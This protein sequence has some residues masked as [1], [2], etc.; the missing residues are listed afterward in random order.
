MY[1]LITDLIRW[2]YVKGWS[3]FR[4]DFKAKLKDT[5]DMFSIGD[6]L[7][8][9][10]KPYRQIAANNDSDAI[11]GKLNA[12]LDK[13]VSRFVGMITRL[14]LIFAGVIVM[15]LEIIIG[16]VMILIWPLIPALPIAGVVLAIVGVAL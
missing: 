9:L 12:F 13:L 7:R 10:F 5:A 2:W 6:L 8:T 15:L 14:V 1:M 16:G 11:Q 3:V 4:G